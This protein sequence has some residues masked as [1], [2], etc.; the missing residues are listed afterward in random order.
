MGRKNMCKCCKEIKFMMMLEDLI[1]TADTKAKVQLVERTYKKNKSLS[2]TVTLAE[3]DLNYCP[4]C[5]KKL[6]WSNTND[7]EY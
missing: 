3:Y 5:G 4:M 7:K 6:E 1:T 2:G